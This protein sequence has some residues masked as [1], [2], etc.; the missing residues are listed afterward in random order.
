MTTLGFIAHIFSTMVS[1]REELPDLNEYAR[2]LSEKV[3]EYAGADGKLTTIVCMT[4]GE[5]FTRYFPDVNGIAECG[6]MRMWRWAYPYGG[7]IYIF[8]SCYKCSKE[9]LQRITNPSKVRQATAVMTERLSK[10]LEPAMN[11]QLY[12]KVIAIWGIKA[13]AVVVPQDACDRNSH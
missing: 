13:G 12:R 4:C 9:H 3:A 2:S 5:S 10:S 11:P 1:T 7:D 6:D 8:M